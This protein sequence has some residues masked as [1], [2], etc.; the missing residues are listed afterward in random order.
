MT[1]KKKT[2]K[3]NN[4][5]KTSAE[6]LSI[7]KSAVTKHQASYE[8]IIVEPNRNLNSPNN[9]IENKKAAGLYQ[10]VATDSKLESISANKLFYDK[11]KVNI[12]EAGNALIYE[13]GDKQWNIPKLSDKVVIKDTKFKDFGI[14]HY[15]SRNKKENA[16]NSQTHLQ[17]R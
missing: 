14:I 9:D 15:Y 10:M 11:F 17:K 2:A 13:L 1:A 4:I 7:Q 6:K 8:F 12:E 16:L 3:D 5:D